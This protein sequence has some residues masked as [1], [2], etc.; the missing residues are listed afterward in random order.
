MPKL[1]DISTL[2]STVDVQVE[3]PST[4]EEADK[5]LGETG[6]ALDGFIADC[7]AR[8][9]LPRLYKAVAAELEK[10]GFPAAKVGSK[11]TTK[12]DAEGKETESETDVYETD[13]KHVGRVYTEGDE[14]L[15]KTITAL[16]Q[17][18]A[19]T[20]P[21]YAAGDRSGSGKISEQNMT[22]ASD[23]IEAGNAAQAIEVIETNTPNY[24]VQVDEAGVP[25][26]EALARGIA[27]MNKHLVAEA[28]RK[29]KGL[30]GLAGR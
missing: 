12:K 22:A 13:I 2:Y 10:T 4:Y 21:F 3:V 8:N 1:L 11:K 30:L 16:L 27:A 29:S 18:T 23:L 17:T 15:K 14:E 19:K 28:A 24:K 20:I 9:F 25:T 6:G 7:S 5:L 26:A